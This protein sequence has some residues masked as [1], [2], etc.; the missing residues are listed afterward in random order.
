[1][2]LATAEGPARQAA[3]PNVTVAGKV[4][5]AE[6]GGDA[7][8]HA[9]FVGFAPARPGASPRFA[10]A[11]VV[12]HGGEGGQVAAPIAGRLLELALAMP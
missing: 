8:P 4:G 9:W 3:A 10:I 2:A 6:T 1:M 12:E 7:P 11:V 5:T